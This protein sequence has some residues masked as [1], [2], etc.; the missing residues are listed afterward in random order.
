MDAT[1]RVE[2]DALLEAGERNQC[3]NVGEVAEVAE[4]LG[5]DD[6]DVAG[7]YAEI[8]EHGIPLS[9]DCARSGVGTTEVTNA[10]VADATTDALELFLRDVRRF[11][12][13]TREQER[14]L[15]QRVERGDAGAKERM[16][17]S[18]LRLVVS[19]ARRYHS[20]DLT[21]LDLIQEGV[22]GLIR[23]VEK[24]DWRRNLK[25]STY[26]TLWIQQAIQRALANQSRVIRLP[27]HVVERE[28]RIARAQRRLTARLG[29]EP[30]DE[31]IGDE[32]RL[33]V[34]RIWETRDAP[35]AV[36]SLDRPIGDEDETP[37]GELLARTD[38]EPFAEIE[39]ALRDDVIDQAL[40]ELSDRDRRVL[41]LRYG[42]DGGE[43]RTLTS[44]GKELGV[45]RER[46][47][48]IE[49]QAL[50]RL[51]EA[52]ELQALRDAA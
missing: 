49:R 7:L 26:A 22:L 17:N 13:L 24:F 28:L 6:D 16:V 2:I 42:L 52:R 48:Q 31:E 25:F 44:I 43:P 15:A 50:E 32:A 36:T 19:I 30:T 46:V 3:L 14:E 39:V 51:A 35:R 11:P 29:R 1:T 9:D 18:N 5:L 40:S 8:E 38:E 47:R 37:L 23:A 33:P 10:A 12:L 41:R 21:L 20:R 45:T 27:V 4:R 34:T